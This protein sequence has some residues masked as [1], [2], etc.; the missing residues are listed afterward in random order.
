MQS[1]HAPVPFAAGSGCSRPNT[2]SPATGKLAIR[3]PMSPAG[4][5]GGSS[6]GQSSGELPALPGSSSETASGSTVADAING[7]VVFDQYA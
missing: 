1:H 4:S 3:P 5:A 7:A 6:T 2:V